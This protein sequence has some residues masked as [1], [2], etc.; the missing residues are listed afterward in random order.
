[1]QRGNKAAANL[2]PPSRSYG[3]SRSLPTH[4]AITATRSR[5]S[6]AQTTSSPNGRNSAAYEMEPP[7]QQPG[8]ASKRGP[9][10]CRMISSQAPGSLSGPSALPA[11]GA[12][13]AK[14]EACFAAAAKR[15]GAIHSPDRSHR[16]LAAESNP[17]ARLHK[18]TRD[19]PLCTSGSHGGRC[20]R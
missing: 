17:R 18:A 7:P 14:A 8:R 6:A 20:H 13:L 11:R 4:R 19:K 16:T 5:C 12:F 3:A 15:Q 9:P 2:R 10:A 1:M